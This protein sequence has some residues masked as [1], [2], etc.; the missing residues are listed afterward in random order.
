MVLKLKHIRYNNEPLSPYSTEEY[1]HQGPI[2]PTILKYPRTR[3]SRIVRSS[4]ERPSW[5]TGQHVLNVP[6]HWGYS[7][8]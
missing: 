2:L 3:A 6:F 1:Q 4:E 7:T 8:I 5:K